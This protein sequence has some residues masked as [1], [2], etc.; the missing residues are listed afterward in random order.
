MK[1]ILR[2][3]SLNYIIISIIILVLILKIIPI[4]IT[5]QELSKLENEKG[6]QSQSYEELEK[7]Y[8]TLMSDE[9]KDKY[10][11]QAY[12]LSKKGELLFSF[13]DSSNR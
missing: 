13:P 7:E 9:N 10:F 4:I 8:E 2:S 5:S 11:R 6:E 1:K 3:S 12:K